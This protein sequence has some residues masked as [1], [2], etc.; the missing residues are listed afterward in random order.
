MIYKFRDLIQEVSEKN[1]DLEYGLNDIVGVTIEKGIIPTIANLTQTDLNKFYIVNPGTF[2]YNPRTHGVRIGMGYNNSNK[3]YITT[4]NNVAF[5]VKEDAKHLVNPQYL[6]M[7]F[8]RTEWDRETNYYAMGSST[9][10]FP[11]TI[12]MEL[13]I[14]LPTKERQDE[15]VQIYQ[16]IN[17]RIS[18]KKKIN[19]NLEA[20]MG[21]LFD[22][23][24]VS[25]DEH[26]FNESLD[27][28]IDF[29]NGLAMQNFRPEADEIALPV[30]KIRELSQ[31]YC[32]AN[33]EYC[34]ETIDKTHIIHNGDLVFSWSGSL[35]AAFW[36][37][38]TA[39]LN[40]HLFK[41]QSDKYPLWFV[42]R[43]VIFHLLNFQRIAENKGTTFGHIKREDLH[44]AKIKSLNVKELDALNQV[45]SPM[46]N[47]I[48][49][50]A[51]ELHSLMELQ[52][53]IL[54]QLSR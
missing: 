40:Q 11:W 52:S 53:V 28:N 19:D 44:N 31:G 20:Q 18:L 47:A 36:T 3:T 8:C 46:L 35:Q 25:N 29:I 5:R 7:Y 30:I 12:F 33:S 23:Y 49:D 17:E 16:I 51:T 37:S 10:V 38:K 48:I 32:D 14:D 45:F 26:E 54:A 39:G 1:T 6:W 21:A 9:I 43:W 2:I 24:V 42:Y 27:D 50:N 22:E 15:I 41:V 34:S 4:W 13:Q